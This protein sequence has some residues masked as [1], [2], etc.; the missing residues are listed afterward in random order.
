MSA[1]PILLD[2]Q[3]AARARAALNVLAIGAPLA[4]AGAAVIWRMAGWP[5]ATVMAAVTLA[6][7]FGVAWLRARRLDRG[8]LIAALDAR[9]GAFEDSSGLLF[10]ADDKPGLAGLQRRRLEA[11]IAEARTIDL[12]PPWASREILAAWA[13]A[14]MVV[15]ASLLWPSATGSVA[16]EAGERGADSIGPVRVVEQRIRITPPA[17]TGLPAREQSELDI[18]APAGSRIEWVLAFSRTPKDARLAFVDGGTIALGEAGTGLSAAYTATEPTL[19]RIE[20]V[21]LR[22]RPLNRLEVIA[23][24]PPVV[25]LISPDSQLTLATAGQTAWTPVFEATD[26]YGVQATAALRVTVTEGEG[27]ATTSRTRTVPIRGEG[28]PKRRRY[29]LPLNLAQEGLAPGGDLIVQ[30]IVRDQRAG[31]PQ[32]VEGP[33]AILRWPRDVGLAEGL[34]GMAASTMPAYFRSQ[35]Q[36]IIDAEALIAERA[37]L[38]AEDFLDRS[39]GL[40]NDQAQLR[41]RYGQ[42]MGEESEGAG[43]GVLALPTNDAPAGPALPLHDAETPAAAPAP[44]HHADDGHDHSGHDDAPGA[45]TGAAAVDGAMDVVRQ[46]GHVHDDSDAATLFDPGTRSTLALALDAMWASERALRQSRPSEA[47]PHANRALDLLK[48]AQQATRVFLPRTGSGPPPIDPSR[49]LTG[50]REDIA[51][52]PLPPVSVTGL[53]PVL[54]DAWTALDARPGRPAA[55]VPLDALAQ[56]ARRNRERLADPLALLAAI[57][58]VRGDPD[59][60]DCRRRLRGLVWS[61]FDPPPAT[62]TRRPGPTVRGARYLEALR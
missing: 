2:L 8:W 46:F 47:L 43:S 55:P 35:R 9:L 18:E 29:A 33:S 39:N 45:D 27:E 50:D 4:L 30:L 54:V 10:E 60:A 6:A 15:A 16:S 44:E 62:A 7:T 17:Y 36:I 22:R 32:E 42:F 48:D 13:A 38:T 58:A 1:S 40:G 21:G 61:A 41:L 25:S 52:G 19:Y 3:R 26:D 12:R 37:R 49:R 11:R 53:D 59:C 34:D 20:A 24:A 57:D 51:V 31:G 56:W 23:D 5:A 14:A 28:E